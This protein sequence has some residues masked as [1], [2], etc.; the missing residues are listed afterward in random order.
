M[1][2][3]NDNSYR[4]PHRG[5]GGSEP[6]GVITVWKACA[7]CPEVQLRNCRRDGTRC[8]DLAPPGTPTQVASANPAGLGNLHAT[9]LSIQTDV[10]IESDINLRPCAIVRHCVAQTSCTNASACRRCDEA[11]SACDGSVRGEMNHDATWPEIERRHSA[12]GDRRSVPRGG[13]RRFDLPRAV[14]C[15]RCSGRDVRGLGRGA[16]GFW[17]ECRRCRHVWAI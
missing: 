11:F 16:A 4:A 14:V 6:W 15:A 17:C 12:E 2:N 13:Q 9:P 3:G 8:V 7:Q 1:A 10:C 5:T